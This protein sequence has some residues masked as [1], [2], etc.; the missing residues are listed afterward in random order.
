[1]RRMQGAAAKTASIAAPKGGYA[2]ARR[3]NL[4][5]RFLTTHHVVRSRL[6]I[7]RTVFLLNPNR[8]PRNLWATPESNR[9]RSK[10]LAGAPDPDRRENCIV[11]EQ[12]VESTPKETS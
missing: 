12:D 7:S 5:L 3:I 10:G 6:T 9:S 8:I 1:M 2:K 11:E 4:Q